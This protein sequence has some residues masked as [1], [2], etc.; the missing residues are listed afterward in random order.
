MGDSQLLPIILPAMG[1]T[2]IMELTGCKRHLIHLLFHTLKRYKALIVPGTLLAVFLINIALLSAAA[3]VATVGAILIPLLI[4][5]G[6]RPSIAA[7]IV[8]SGTW[9]AVMNPSSSHAAIISKISDVSI[10]QVVLFHIPATL[11][12]LLF[13]S[14][15][16]TII[17]IIWKKKNTTN[18]AETAIFKELIE[19]EKEKISY[20]KA[21]IPLCPLILLFISHQLSEFTGMQ[22]LKLSVLEV[23]IFSSI[24]GTIVSRSNPNEATQEFYTGMGKA[25]SSAIGLIISAFVFVEGLK[26][27]DLDILLIGYLQ[28]AQSAVP[29]L[30]ILTSMLFTIITG[31]GDA[32]AVTLN[33]T[34]TPYAG[35]F[36]ISKLFLGNLIWIGAEIGRAVSPI[37]MATILVAGFAHVSPFAIIRWTWAPMLCVALLASFTLA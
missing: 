30:S 18:I 35:Q 17:S 10:I 13:T 19:I 2:A 20:I 11:P 23:M 21:L 29:L 14:I 4:A 25:Y 26:A 33:T 8:L 16:M 5:F 22:K 28:D 1:F 24:I 6:I 34:I 9:G 37:S 31:S 32:L 27:H 3:T 15:A 7:A 12:G 36:E